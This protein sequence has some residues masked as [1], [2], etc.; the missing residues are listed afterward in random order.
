V[1]LEHCRSCC[2]IPA[3]PHNGTRNS[4][5]DRMASAVHGRFELWDVATYNAFSIEPVPPPNDKVTIL[6]WYAES[7]HYRS[8][9]GGL[10]LDRVLL[11]KGPR[12]FGNR[13]MP[14]NVHAHL[15]S[16]NEAQEI[17]RT[18]SAAEVA[19]V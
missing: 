13:L 17:Y 9:L 19:D 10:M 12:E 5:I 2:L 15:Q 14:A 7:S 8:T 6:Q 18:I 3:T 16:Q 11:G 4:A 1:R